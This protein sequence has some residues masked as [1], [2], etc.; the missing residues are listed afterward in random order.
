[1]SNSFPS[2][3]QL[4]SDEARIQTW[5]RLTPKPVPACC[6]L[7]L[8]AGLPCVRPEAYPEV[9]CK[10]CIWKVQETAAAKSGNETRNRRPTES[11]LSIQLP[12]WARR[13]PSHCG[14]LETSTVPT[15]S[16]VQP[17]AVVSSNG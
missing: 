2:I 9:D 4:V 17:S 5:V 15:C 7:P 12:P 14:N 3:T 16:I 13:A 10:Q 8:S 11:V 6:N 1:M